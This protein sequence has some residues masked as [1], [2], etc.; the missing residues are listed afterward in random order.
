MEERLAA[1]SA[2][3]KHLEEDLDTARKDLLQSKDRKRK[4][5]RDV[6]EI[7]QSKEEIALLLRWNLLFGNV[8]D[9]LDTLAT[10]YPM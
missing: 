5:E 8:V 2:H 6:R 1:L 10:W 4:L 7:F 9:Q 3:V